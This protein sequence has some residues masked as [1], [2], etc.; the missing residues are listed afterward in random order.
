[1]QLGFETAANTGVRIADASVEQQGLTE[2]Q[3]A[4]ACPR[5]R[6]QAARTAAKSMTRRIWLDGCRPLAECPGS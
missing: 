3:R 1:M 6:Y 4:A 5:A 2:E